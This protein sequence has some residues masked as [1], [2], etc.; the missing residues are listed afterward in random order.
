MKKVSF[1]VSVAA[2]LLP[3]GAFADAHEEEE[4]ALL[5]DVWWVVPKKGMEAEFFEA[6]EAHMAFRAEAGESRSWWAYTVAAGKNT[7]PVQFRSCCFDWADFDAHVA[8]DQEKGFGEHWN[9][10]VDQYVDH[11]HHYIE[12]SDME[13]SHWPDEGTDGP[14]YGVT[15]W[16]YKPWSGPA[17]DEARKKLS[18]VALENGWAKD[19][20]NWVWMTRQIGAPSLSIVS[21]YASF[22][23]MEPPEQSFFEFIA[24]QMGSPEEASEVFK[25]FNSGFSGSD[26]TIWVQN[27][28]LSTP[29]DDD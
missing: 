21:S 14:Y 10:N 20:N 3:I 27:T 7:A 17:P 25:V 29:S 13:N 9:A 8:E 15:T 4:Q 5:S 16:S 24:E 28:A 22:A 18:Q 11:Y 26:F 19:D 1:I 23:E 2:L 6:A 12:Q